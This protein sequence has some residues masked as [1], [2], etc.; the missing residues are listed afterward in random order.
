MIL[1]EWM[2]HWTFTERQL[3]F[4]RVPLSCQTCFLHLNVYFLEI[5]NKSVRDEFNSL[6]YRWWNWSSDTQV[7]SSRTRILI[8]S[9]FWLCMP[10]PASWPPPPHLL[11]LRWGNWGTKTLSRSFQ[12]ILLENGGT[13]A[14]PQ[15]PGFLSPISHHQLVLLSISRTLAAFPKHGWCS[16]ILT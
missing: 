2:N 5:H 16:S 13:E 11:F 6:C 15:T 4:Y 12:V 3:Q 14:R 7:L 8:H 1:T 10:S 9:V